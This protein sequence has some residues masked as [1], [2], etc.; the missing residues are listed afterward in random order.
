MT[1]F[2]ISD[3]LASLGLTGAHARQARLVLEAE[4]ITNPRKTR[5]SVVKMDRAERAINARFARLCHNC[6]GHVAFD[7]RERVRVR[8]DACANCGGSRTARALEELA[9]A[10]RAGGVRR[11]VVVGGSPDTR[12][13]L[14]AIDGQP[15]LRLVDGTERRTRS[16][17]QGDLEWAD[18]VIVCG[19][20]QLAHKV[21]R[22][23]T[24]ARTSTPVVTASRRGLEAIAV[25]AVEHLER[26]RHGR[27]AA[28]RAE[29]P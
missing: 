21:S 27:A 12:G 26:H 23:Y 3:V 2:P 14:A 18:L 7:G 5:L 29:R 4:G 19:A 15:Q 1:D 8:P 9:A 28:A 17:A 10:C 24:T 13:G 20:T 25:A 11:L 16:K 6:E 22:L